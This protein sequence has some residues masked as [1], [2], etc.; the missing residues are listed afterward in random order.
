VLCLGDE[1]KPFNTDERCEAMFDKPVALIRTMRPMTWISVMATIF[2][3][4]MISLGAIPPLTDIFSISIL[5]PIFVL[6]YAN[7]LNAYTDYKIDKITRPERAIPKGIIKKETVLYFTGVLFL[8]AL[9]VAVLVLSLFLSLFV[10]A[11]LILGTAYS[12]N[13]TRIKIHSAAAPLAIAVG[14]VFIPLVGASLL[15]SPLRHDILLI[16]FFLT[17]QT[18]G[19][20]VSKDFIDLKGD[21][22]LKVSTLPLIM[23]LKKAQIV[24][25]SGLCIPLGVFPVLSLV[26]VLPREFLLYVIFFLWVFYIG[27]LYRNKHTYEKAYIHSFFFCAA[28]I[29]LSGIAYT[30]GIL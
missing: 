26:Q 18:A 19:A 11:G 17:L 10:I 3:G 28:S 6:G 14:Y 12:I 27:F 25:L 20:S 1:R 2:A 23:G 22:A 13:P 8:G 24:V 21:D 4:M 30:G 5:L 16:A 9:I 7:S 29:F 15:Y